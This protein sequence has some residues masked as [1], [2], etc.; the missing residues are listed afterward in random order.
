MPTLPPVW[1]MDDATYAALS[2]QEKKTVS[3]AI[4]DY[5]KE[6]AEARQKATNAIVDIL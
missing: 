2:K 3:K 6:E 1:W 5:E 4:S